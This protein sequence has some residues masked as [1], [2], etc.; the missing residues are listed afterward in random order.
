MVKPVVMHVSTHCDVGL[1]LCGVKLTD[2]NRV[3]MDG[4][5]FCIPCRDKQRRRDAGKNKLRWKN[6]FDIAAR[7]S[8]A[9]Y[10]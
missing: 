9:L 6:N 8:V 4:W 7:A 1:M 10:D 5:Q 2:K 3:S